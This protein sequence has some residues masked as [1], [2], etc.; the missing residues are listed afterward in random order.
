MRHQI[1]LLVDHRD[2]RAQRIH[3]VGKLHWLP[4]HANRPFIGAIDTDQ[5]FHQRGFTGA[6][7]AHQGMHRSRTHAQ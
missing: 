6:V 2:P 3:G 5:A 4:F 7:L 1:E